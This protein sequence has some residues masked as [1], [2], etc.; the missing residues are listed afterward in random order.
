MATTHA[1]HTAPRSAPIG[2]PIDAPAGSRR[3]WAGRLPDGIA[4]YLLASIV[5]FFLAGS[6]APTPLYSTY[7]AEWGFSPITTTVVFG[8]YAVAVLAALLTVGKI[9]DHVGRRPVLLIAIAGQILAM[10]VF[11]SA[12]GVPILLLARV[13]QGLATGAAAGAVGAALLDLDQRRGTLANALSTPIGTGLGSIGA[14]LLVQFLP[15]PTRLVYALLIGVFVL[16]GLGVA[17]MRET[18]TT[19][20]GAL[21][22]LRPEFALPPRSRRPLLRSVPVLIAAWALAGFYG[23][24]SPALVRQL[25]GSDAL[26]LGGLPLFVLAGSGATAVAV[27]RRVETP[28]VMLL[29]TIGLAA[30]VGVTLLA[31]Q[32]DSTTG[33][34]A[35]SIV[36]GFGFGAAFQAVIRTVVPTAEA[37]QRAGLLS[38][39]YTLSYLAMGLPAVIGGYLAVHEGLLTT[40]SQYGLVVIALALA[41]L[42]ALAVEARGA[43]AQVAPALAPRPLELAGA[44]C[45]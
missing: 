16:Q 13:V 43:A 3:P 7:A 25:A 1:G 40:A 26:L 29:G 34:F 21:A 32:G 14:G 5:V 12:D 6:S 38:V 9:S 41:A 31:V 8:V 45:D 44:G 27:L 28:R 37:H 33:F 20:P 15:A 24:L 36:A 11:L 19:K 30:G 23:A 39:V 2:A 42:V 10:T 35:G 22:S 4:F 17:T 18:V